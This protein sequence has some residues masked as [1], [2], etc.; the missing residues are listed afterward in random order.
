MLQKVGCLS[1]V[2]L[3][4]RTGSQVGE[5]AELK[6]L[7]DLLGFVLDLPKGCDGQSKPA[8]D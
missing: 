8:R 2:L 7:R 6:V 1:K 5:N 3:G 4:Q